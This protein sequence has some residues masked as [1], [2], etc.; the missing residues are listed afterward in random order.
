MV[1]AEQRLTR[2]QDW[3]GD[4]RADESV[5]GM[6]V[7]W[8][9]DPPFEWQDFDGHGLKTCLSA[10]AIDRPPQVQQLPPNGSVGFVWQSVKLQRQMLDR[11]M[12]RAIQQPGL[13]FQIAPPFDCDMSMPEGI[14]LPLASPTAA[15]VTDRVA[16]VFERG[17]PDIVNRP[18][19]DLEELMLPLRRQNHE[20][21]VVSQ[22]L[23]I[24]L[25][26]PLSPSARRF[27]HSDPILLDE[28]AVDGAGVLPRRDVTGH[29]EPVAMPEIATGNLL[30]KS[31]Q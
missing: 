30:H 23:Q 29:I 13:Q 7:K 18:G 3:E 11:S 21:P 9:Y 8:T 10:A 31:L 28:L 16:A 25:T 12:D 19:L 20:Q 6:Y 26:E 5:R 15:P 1:I 24:R 4:R 27:R 14:P 22:V 2:A 17:P